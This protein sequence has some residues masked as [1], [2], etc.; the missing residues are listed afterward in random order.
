MYVREWNSL[1]ILEVKLHIRYI[2][3]A[4]IFSFSRLPFYSIHCILC[5]RKDFKF[6]IVLLVYLSFCCLCFWCYVPEIIAKSSVVKLFLCAFFLG[7]LQFHFLMFRSFI[8]FELIFV[9]H[10]VS[11]NLFF[12]MWISNFPII[13]C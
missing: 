7:A 12:C 2:W 8:H 13:I 6:D 11:S 1:Y 3:F 9:Y 4:K 5:Y 10:I